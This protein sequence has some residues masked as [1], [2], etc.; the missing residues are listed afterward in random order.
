MGKALLYASGAVFAAY[1]LACLV[2]PG[3]A[4]SAAGLAATGADGRAELGGMYGGF[5][6]GFG[7]YLLL[8]A[9]RPALM[10]GGLWALLLGIG[11]L[12][13]ARAGHAFLASGEATVYSYGAI[14]FEGLLALLAALAL[15]RRAG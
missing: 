3:I 15:R 4:A 7:L 9:W 2:D 13:A 6:T 12:A 1:G 8:C 14:A 10:T 11:P 5:Q